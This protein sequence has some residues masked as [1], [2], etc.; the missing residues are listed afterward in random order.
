MDI[1]TTNPRSKRTEFH[2]AIAKEALEGLIKSK[3]ERI[4]HVTVESKNRALRA[5]ILS[6]MAQLIN[7]YDIMRDVVGSEVLV[8][9]EILDGPEFDRDME[10]FDFC[11]LCAELFDVDHSDIT[12]GHAFMR[13]QIVEAFA[14]RPIT[15]SH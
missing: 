5:A 1:M 4:A 7:I 14:G 9:S 12:K 11:M 2:I 10:D 13:Q 3:D 8:F 6:R 15:S